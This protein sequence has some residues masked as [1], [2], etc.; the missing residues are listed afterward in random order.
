MPTLQAMEDEYGHGDDFYRKK[1]LQSL[2]MWQVNTQ[3]FVLVSVQFA[4][5]SREML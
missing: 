4:L 3:P 2:L 1:C 5:L